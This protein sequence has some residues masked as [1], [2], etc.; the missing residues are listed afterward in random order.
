MLGI[1]SKLLDSNEK[2]IKKLAPVVSKINAREAEYKA[3]TDAQLKD[4][5]LEFRQ[6]IS[7][8]VKGLASDNE[9]LTALRATL[10]ELLPDAFAA[11]REAG[12]RALGKRHFDVQLMAGIALHQL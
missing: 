8:V 7:S 5:T 3:L 12:K 9:R 4:K 10:D 1:L 2:Q 11:V 6:R